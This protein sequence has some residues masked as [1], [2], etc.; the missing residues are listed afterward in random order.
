MAQSLAEK[1]REHRLVME[2]ALRWGVTPA[3][4]KLRMRAEANQR[5]RNEAEARA[6][7]RES[8]PLVPGMLLADMAHLQG[9]A[10]LPYW[11]QG[12]LA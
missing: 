10:A 11:K 6:K 1:Y 12:D 7:A 9:E 8:A 4:A 3:Q 2:A 5:Y